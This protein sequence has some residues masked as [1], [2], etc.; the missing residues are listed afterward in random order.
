GNAPEYA[1][2]NHS[3][4]GLTVP[5]SDWQNSLSF[6]CLPVK[7][8]RRKSAVRTGVRFGEISG[9]NSIPVL[10]IIKG[11]RRLRGWLRFAGKKLLR[12]GGVQVG[13]VALPLR[14]ASVGELVDVAGLP[15]VGTRDRR[16]LLHAS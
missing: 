4:L 13:M 5:S 1:S 14:Q 7:S 3:L 11:L 8:Y 2:L 9:L 12:A 16:A 15:A 10:V 6:H